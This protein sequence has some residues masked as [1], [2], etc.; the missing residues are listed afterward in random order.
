M[1]L[2]PAD[3]VVDDGW[4]IGG[5]IEEEYGDWSWSALSEGHRLRDVKSFVSSVVKG[6]VML[7]LF[8]IQ[9]EF[10]FDSYFHSV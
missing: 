3:C 2:A 7:S 8:D 6:V 10:F 4:V 1:M 9:L 5:W